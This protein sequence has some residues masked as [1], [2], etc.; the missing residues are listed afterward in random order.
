MKTCIS[1]G[2]IWA[3]IAT[4]L[5]SAD[6]DIQPDLIRL[7]ELFSLSAGNSGQATL[8]SGTTMLTG[9]QF[10]SDNNSSAQMMTLSRKLDEVS[11]H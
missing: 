2:N 10:I 6:T 3:T 5:K 4:R 7:E 8:N 9:D 1:T 11:L